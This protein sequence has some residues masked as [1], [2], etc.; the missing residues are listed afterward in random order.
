MLI[1]KA[2]AVVSEA[3]REQI[4]K[5]DWPIG[6]RLPSVEKLAELFQVGRSTIREALASLKAQGW[7]DVRHGGGTFVLKD[8]EPVNGVWQA[9]EIHDIKQLQAWIELR[10][11]LETESAGL[12]AKRRSAEQIAQLKQIIQ[13]MMTLQEESQLDQADI[14]FH[15]AIAQA[16]GNPLLAG[17]LESLF[18]SM[19]PIMRESR[20]LWLFAEQSEASRLSDEHLQ[21]VEAIENGSSTLAKKR[22]ASHLRKVEQTLQRLSNS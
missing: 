6:S 2:S 8:K 4:N 14:R 19:G 7:V 3:I 17:T 21:L 15:V 13:E 1:P 22:M 12:A 16:S 10:Y 9:P 18:S 5:G 11:I 20:R